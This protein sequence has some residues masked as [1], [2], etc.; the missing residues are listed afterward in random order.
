MIVNQIL[1]CGAFHYS[2]SAVDPN[3]SEVLLTIRSYALYNRSRTVLLGLLGWGAVLIGIATVPL[4]CVHVNT[5]SSTLILVV[6]DNTNIC[7][8]S[9]MV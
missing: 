2:L 1:A 3:I 9:T 8:W 5:Q 7:H 4:P 6:L